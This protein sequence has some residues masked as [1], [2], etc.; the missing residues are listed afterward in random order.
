M[1]FCG[2]CARALL[3]FFNFIFWLSGATILGIGIWMVVD[4][5]IGIYFKVLQL[6]VTDQFFKISAYILI[7][8]GV[9]V[10]LVGFCGC[11]GAI[12]RSKCLLGMYIFFLVLIFAGELAAGIVM[13]INK[14]KIENQ[15]DTTLKKSITEIYNESSTITEAWDIVQIQLGCC[16]STGAVDYNNSKFETSNPEFKIP[17]SC[18]VLTNKNVAKNDPWKAEAKNKTLCMN[19]EVIGFYHEQGCKDG[20]LNWAKSHSA[21]LIGIGIGIACLQIFGILVAIVLCRQV[22]REEK[23]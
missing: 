5:N 4:K 9:F 19:E 17:L 3:I 20:L 7:A 15:I 14:V 1:G 23:Y 6:D 11:C 21:I 22:D 18:C 12:R 10:F 8:F 2:S 16:G 13:I